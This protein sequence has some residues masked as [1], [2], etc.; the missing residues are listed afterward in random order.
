MSNDAKKI[1]ELDDYLNEV[2]YVPTPGYQPT[3]FAL[4]FVNFIK[5][6]GAGESD[7]TP[8]VHYKMLDGLAGLRQNLVNLCHRGLG[9]TVVFAE[10]LHLYQAVFGEID[11]FGSVNGM[12]YVSD[13]M[14]NGVK[15]FRS[16]VESKYNASEHFLQIYLPNAN[17]TENFIEYERR[18]PVHGMDKFGTRMYGAQS[19]IRGTKIYGG[20]P[21][22]V[23]MDDL[24]K[25][26][27]DA[28]SPAVMGKIRNSI[29]K[30]I[31]PALDPKRRKIVLNG[32]PFNKADI[33]CEA[34]ESGAWHVNVWPVCEQWPCEREEF[35][36]SWP[37]RFTFDA[38][39]AT[40]DLIKGPAFAQEMMLRLTSDDE[41]IVQDTEIR[42]YSYRDWIASRPNYT[43]YITTD[44]ATTEQKKND[45]SVGSVWAVDFQGNFRWIGGY[46]KRQLMDKTVDEIFDLASTHKPLGV[47]LEVTGQQGGFIPWIVK[48]QIAR[49]EFFNLLSHGNGNKPGIRV[50]NSKL[51]RFH[52]VAPLI[53]AGK[54]MVPNDIEH[55]WLTEFWA[56]IRLATKNG[57]KSKHDDVLDTIS[58]LYLI[59]PVLPGTEYAVAPDP[60]MDYLPDGEYALANYL[61]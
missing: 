7:Q 30:G 34:V 55:P 42:T 26:D 41:R 33:M 47:A 9:K 56:E 61:A 35:R 13:A 16:N 29:Y 52:E 12:L 48:E 3:K 49:N 19:G 60:E 27:E 44:F 54:I 23:I 59:T 18:S 15:N 36:S 51:Q 50:V 24:I 14:D 22:L 2:S 37:D 6:V 17:F 57:L 5:M 20:R 40:A 53:K 38:V 8:E 1:K 21:Q 32:T 31:I 46:C 45:F 11:G 4:R 39:K 43:T 25:S 28:A 58:Q 10:Y